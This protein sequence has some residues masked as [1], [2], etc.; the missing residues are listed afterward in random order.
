MEIRSI[1]AEL[2]SVGRDRGSV[3]CH[4]SWFPWLPALHRWSAPPASIRSSPC[5]RS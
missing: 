3:R 4:C 5:A 1:G 2:E